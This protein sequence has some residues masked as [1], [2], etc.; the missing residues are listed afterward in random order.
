MFFAAYFWSI[1]FAVALWSPATF[2]GDFSVRG[3]PDLPYHIKADSLSYDDN[4]KRYRARGRVIITKGDQCLRADAV[5][6]NAETMETEAWGNVRFTSGEDWLTGT[7]LEMNLD[8]AIGTL[9]DG[10]L[11][12]KESHFYI[13]G[14]KIEKTGKDSYHIADGGFTSCDGDSPAW[15]VTGKDLNVT[16]NG[17]STVKHV[18]L[19]AKSVPVLYAPFLVFPAKTERQTGFLVPQVFYSDRNGFEYNQPFFWAISES[20]DATFYESHMAH[21]GFKHGIEYRYVL[22]PESKGAVMSDF[23]YDRQIDDSTTPQHSGGYH[24]EG[25]RG[26]DEDRL[27]RKRWWFRMKNDQD[28]P[29]GFKAKLDID[30]VSDQD[31]LREFKSGYTG[32]RSTDSYFQKEFGRDMDDY[33]DMVRL[34]RLNLNRNWDQYSLNADLRWYDDVIT[35]KNDDPDST[36]QRLP[37][38][39]FDASRQKL[40][41]QPLYFDLESSYDYFW[42]EYGARGHRVDLHPRLYYPMSLWECLDFEP[43]VGLRETIWQVEEYGDETPRKGNRLLSREVV[44]FKADLSTEISRTFHL[45]GKTAD[46]IR[47]TLKPQ[48]VYD[49]VPVPAQGD[50][51]NFEGIDRIEK[52]NVLTYSITNYLTL[53]SINRH[54][55]DPETHP[56]PPEGPEPPEYSYR[57]FCRIKFS[58]SYDITEA[59]GD[60]GSANKRPFSDIKGELEFRPYDCLDLDGDV[61]WSPYDDEF[62]SYNAILALCDRR[63]NRGSLDYRYT[64][65]NSKSILTKVL[66]KLFDPVSA[67][68]EHERNLKEGKD[69]ETVIGFRYEPQ[70]WALNVSFTYDRAMDT[71]EY[72]VEVSLYGLGKIGL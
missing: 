27:N 23:L 46:R 36:L 28:L 53:R 13:R 42:R 38:I 39:R 40:S 37:H 11:F 65:G 14:G 56:A 47:H 70:C 2:A 48:V 25:F 68:W 1:L 8:A 7:R 51:P 17:Y 6:F 66:V 26:D 30:V 60:K 34:N 57:D 58:Q 4:T 55:R 63:G 16:L 64:E 3:G 69:V 10:T 9:Y 22:A 50:C 49:Y 54:N 12:I 29:A 44:D 19:W 52:K 61:T 20:S 21:R 5:D 32:F 72:F 33:T 43:S 62:K 71:R 41:A 24:Y 45:K 67:Y 31:Y 15:K 35:R 18:V 59:R